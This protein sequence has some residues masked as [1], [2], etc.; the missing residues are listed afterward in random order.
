[1]K[2]ISMENEQKLNQA[3]NQISETFGMEEPEAILADALTL[4]LDYQSAARQ[5]DVTK[6][7]KEAAE[8]IETVLEDKGPF[9]IESSTG[10]KTWKEEVTRE[11]ILEFHL[12]VVLQEITNIIEGEE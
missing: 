6:R 11:R 7:L 2:I 1:M 12:E 10:L 4:L 9:V 8:V 5:S 3:I